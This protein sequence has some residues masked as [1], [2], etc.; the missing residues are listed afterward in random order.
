MIHRHVSRNVTHAVLQLLQASRES[1]W[2]ILVIG[3]ADRAC[4]LKMSVEE[5]RV[6]DQKGMQG[7]YS[8]YIMLH[9]LEST[10]QVGNVKLLLWPHI[11]Y[12][13]WAN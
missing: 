7:M 8:V 13:L 1:F 4:K 3:A 9:L 11:Q 10:W 5:Y 2:V 12:A 6:Q